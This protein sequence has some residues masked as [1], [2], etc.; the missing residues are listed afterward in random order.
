MIASAPGNF[1]ELVGMVTRLEEG[2]RG[3][4]LVKESISTDDFEDEDQ[5][6]S[7]VKGWPQQQYPAYHLVAVVMPDANA[8][9]NSGYQP[10][11]LQYQQLTD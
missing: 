6:V 1:V 3:G 9:Q 11:L 2:V 5:E 10:Q 4:R 8:V 7:M